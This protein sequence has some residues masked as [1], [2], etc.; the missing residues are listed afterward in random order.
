MALLVCSA[1]STRYAGG[2]RHCPNCGSAERI[3]EGCGSRLPFLDVA[4]GT[5]TCRSRTVVRRVYLRM[6]APGVVEMPAL[7]CLACGAAMGALN[8]SPT[9]A[10]DD[11]PKITRHGGASN[12]ASSVPP[13]AEG[14]ERGLTDEG[15]DEALPP[16]DGTAETEQQTKKPR[17]RTKTRVPDEASAALEVTAEAEV[18]RSEGLAS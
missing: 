13:A 12:A 18:T 17:R 4:C 2:L 7:A 9:G 11:M 16:A 3:E 8:G 14:T 10:E 1:C 15:S 5:E 6:A